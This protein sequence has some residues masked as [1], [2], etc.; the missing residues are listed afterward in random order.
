[1]KCALLL[2]F[3]TMNATT[4]A[5]SE[6]I[7]TTDILE[8]LEQEIKDIEWRLVQKTQEYVF[9]AKQLSKTRKSRYQEL[10]RKKLAQLIVTLQLQGISP[11]KAPST[12]HLSAPLTSPEGYLIA[13][14]D[15]QEALEK[16]IGEAAS[17]WSN[18]PFLGTSSPC[19]FV[20]LPQP[21]SGSTLATRYLASRG[22]LGPLLAHEI[23][24]LWKFHDHEISRYIDRW[25]M[26][27]CIAA[28]SAVGAM[29]AGILAYNKNFLSKDHD[30]FSETAAAV[31]LA[32][33]TIV[34]GSLAVLY[35][36]IK[37]FSRRQELEADQ[38][39]AALGEPGLQQFITTIVRW[40]LD[41]QLH[42][43]FEP[44]TWLSRQLSPIKKIAYYM[45][46]R[47]L[48]T[49]PS[50]EKRLFHLILAWHTMK[51]RDASSISTLSG[52]EILARIKDDI[53][54]SCIEI[55]NN[56]PELQ[57][58]SIPTTLTVNFPN[59]TLTARELKRLGQL[60]VTIRQELMEIISNALDL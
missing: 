59:K 53:V 37:Q 36:K 5:Y 8:S 11:A 27:L 49:H 26:H 19:I 58:K 52:E 3:F 56:I 21:G 39:V 1:M 51:V 16:H 54:K 9:C 50:H 33:G 46:K 25:N 43:F 2:I 7:V 41:E 42:E 48:G 4:F 20:T 12:Y 23:G 24:H 44:S 14:V 18:N 6:G 45:K 34:T 35:A 29:I 13:I 28:G 60:L 55:I 22:E 15:P 10:C 40:H 30:H 38:F 17:S 31:I 32:G 47:L 57:V